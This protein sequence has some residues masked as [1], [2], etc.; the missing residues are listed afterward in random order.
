[1]SL[2]PAR[3]RELAVEALAAE[4]DGVRRRGGD[5][6]VRHDGTAVTRCGTASMASGACSCAHRSTETATS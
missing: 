3:V 5:G 4:R 2:P 1:M 6:A